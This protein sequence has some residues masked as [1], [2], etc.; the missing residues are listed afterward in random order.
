MFINV[1]VVPSQGPGPLARGSPKA[2][3]GE[4]P[5]LMGICVHLLPGLPLPPSSGAQEGLKGEMLQAHP[6]KRKK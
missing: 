4:A 3:R 2:V 5:G 1:G 6:H